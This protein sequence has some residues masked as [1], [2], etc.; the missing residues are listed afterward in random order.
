MIEWSERIQ[1]R[2]KIH[3]R[4]RDVWKLR[5]VRKRLPFILK[6]L[7]DGE[8]VLE[9]GAHDRALGERIRRHRPHVVYKSLDIDPSYPH[10]YASF[11]EIEETFDLLLLFEVI[12]HLSVDDGMEMIGKIYRVLKPGGRA[13]LTTPDVYAPGQYWKDATHLTPYHYEEIGGLFLSQ[14]FDVLEICR[15]V[16]EP[17]LQYVMKAYLFFPLFRFMGIDFAKSIL[18]AARKV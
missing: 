17:W 14:H 11:D 18:L 4:Y 9:I 13:I 8:A 6:H 12:E 2:G 5:I 7:K 3:E 16:R 1:W 10:D 15:L